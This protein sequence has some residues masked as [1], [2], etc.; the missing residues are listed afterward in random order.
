MPTG[1]HSTNDTANDKLTCKNNTFCLSSSK[2][3]LPAL[4]AVCARIGNGNN[5][6]LG[7][8]AAACHFVTLPVFFS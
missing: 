1:L 5:N 2:K 7:R 6:K 3:N 4:A 8:D